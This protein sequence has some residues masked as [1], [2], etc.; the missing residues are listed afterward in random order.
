MSLKYL[1]CNFVYTE[2]VGS[3]VESFDQTDL[4]WRNIKDLH[5]FFHT[6]I[7]HANISFICESRRQTSTTENGG[8]GIHTPKPFIISNR[9]TISDKR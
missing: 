7:T 4:C 6:Y 9:I 1:I 5:S 3:A 8:V 2:K